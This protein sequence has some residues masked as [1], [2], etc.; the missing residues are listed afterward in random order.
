MKNSADGRKFTSAFCGCISKVSQFQ[1]S[2]FRRIVSEYNSRFLKITFLF[3]GVQLPVSECRV[4][5]FRI[6][7]SNFRIPLSSF[8]IYHCPV[9]EDYFPVS[10]YHFQ[11]P[12]S[13]FRIPPPVSECHSPV[14]EYHRDR[15][16]A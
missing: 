6:P 2:S 5:S 3:R 11:F 12:N 14:F 13:L 4:S 1:G 16:R 7:P 15:D 9:S 10:E 8:R